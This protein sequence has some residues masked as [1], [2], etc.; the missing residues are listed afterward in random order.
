MYVYV[1]NKQWY[2]C[3]CF[4]KQV[5]TVSQFWFMFCF[6][7]EWFPVISRRFFRENAGSI[8]KMDSRE[9]KINKIFRKRQEIIRIENINNNSA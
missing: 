8:R 3:V 1:K 6:Y 2:D 7:L 5:C 4:C 9:N